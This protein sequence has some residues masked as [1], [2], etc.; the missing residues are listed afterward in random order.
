MHQSRPQ[1]KYRTVHGENV[2]GGGHLIDPLVDRR[3]A[4]RILSAGDFDA[5]LQLPK[6][7]GADEKF[8]VLSLVQPRNDRPVRSRSAELGNDVGVEEIH[9]E[10]GGRPATTVAALGSGNVATGFLCQ[11]QFFEGWLAIGLKATPRCCWDQ[12]RGLYP[13]TCHHLRSFGQGGVEHFTEPRF[14][15]LSRPCL[16][17]N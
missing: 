7:N 5:C 4:R 8:V 14:G 9:S 1:S 16:H 11:K 6:G 10:G 2:V 12:Y 17:S 13:A 15:V 3:R